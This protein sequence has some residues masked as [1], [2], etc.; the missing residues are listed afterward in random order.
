M[1]LING[2]LFVVMIT[3]QYAC[4]H[5]QT[6]APEIKKEEVYSRY[7]HEDYQWYMNN[8]PFFQCSDTSIEQVY[9]YRWKLYK[10]H[11]RNTGPDEYVVTEFINHVPWDRDPY[12]TINAAS[13][14]H[15]YEGRWL[16]DD[17]YMNGYINNLYHGGNNR[18]YSES[19][20][21]AAYARFL[22]NADTA[23]LI[24]QLDSMISIYNG[25][26]DHY[27]SAKDMYYI[28][29][30]PDATEYTIASI[31]ASG[32]KDGF[33]GGEAFRPTLNSY[34]YGN[35][36]AIAQI[37]K[38]N[39][40][41]V[42]ANKFMDRA[43]LLKKNVEQ[44]LWNDSLQHFTDRFKVN[45]QHVHYWDLIRGREL[46]GMIPWYFDLPSDN[47]K[48]STAWQHVL[49]TNNLIGQY[50]FRTNEPSYEYYFKQFV[51]FEGKPGSQWNG[52]S[53]P[54]QSSQALTAMAN[55]LSD[56]KEHNVTNSDYLR[57]L[58]LFTR[59]HYL[60]DGRINLVENY[61]PNNGG[62]IVHY[63]WSN[64][65]LHSSYNNLVISGLCGVRP[66]VGDSLEINP[67]VD[68]SIQYFLLDDVAYHGH[69]LTVVYD[70]DGKKYNV[71]K[72]V[73]VFVDGNKAALQNKK[74]FV[75]SPVKHAK[76][77][78]KTNYALN[79]LKTGFPKP[80]ASVNNT[81]DTSM[82]QAIDG[83]I[84]F[85]SE[86]LNYW[87]TRGSSSSADWY[88]IDFDKDH[89]VSQ[90]DL[91]FYSDS[92]HFF[93]PDTLTVE[94]KNAGSWQVAT[95]VPRNSLSVNTVSQIKFEKLRTTA[96]RL[97]FK[98]SKGDVAISEVE[99]Y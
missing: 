49:D 61:D 85:F 8:V 7:Y 98:H 83:R 96:V 12:C 9:Y 91:Y 69:R 67:L 38:M 72:G 41:P 14:H 81:P 22:V 23:F 77:P 54:Y 71:G 1:K 15:I 32:G 46:A 17:R 78:R 48:F 42:T 4:I 80:S 45:N 39:G 44:Y 87:S 16:R 73:T 26:Y 31:D 89:D 28:P 21:D 18:R 19:I 51:F 33:E 40:D 24:N 58:R 47:K 94:Y 5:E 53:W 82:L 37:A 93:L 86:I 79:I 36:L 27:D 10:A 70:A 52:P 75:G 95:S 57:L 35:A 43:L 11:L 34:M 59:Q 62:P 55:L 68:S 20:A 97:L 88:T 65:Y 92:S 63:F 13:M 3:T 99:V 64:H 56:Y 84:W 30:M 74:V 29:A 60:P 90:V 50:G 76:Q 66:S 6:H 2:V 25:W